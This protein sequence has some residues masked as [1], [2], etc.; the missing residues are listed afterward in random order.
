MRFPGLIHLGSTTGAA[1]RGR[2]QHVGIGLGGSGHG[3]RFPFSRRPVQGAVGVGDP[4]QGGG[5][6]LRPCLVPQVFQPLQVA[7]PARCPGMAG[8]GGP[9]AGDLLV[10]VGQARVMPGV[11]VRVRAG[12][13]E[14]E[15]R[16]AAAVAGRP[17]AG[18]LVRAVRGHSLLPGC[19]RPGGQAAAEDHRLGEFE[20]LTG[21]VLENLPRGPLDAPVRQDVD[22]LVGA[23]GVLQ[24]PALPAALVR[25]TLRSRISA[26]SC[27]A[28]ETPLAL[29]GAPE[30]K[31]G[32]GGAV[33]RM[34]CGGMS[35]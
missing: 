35:H 34:R 3:A 4:G 12:Q 13:A 20:G 2:R 22:A 23:A 5:P 7:G 31:T 10:E 30:G 19:V 15:V 28:E 21:A 29:P 8:Q 25:E 6:G 24:R 26:T 27:T 33:R 11:D 32:D 1:G 16:R 18:G 14:Q 17:G 9:Q